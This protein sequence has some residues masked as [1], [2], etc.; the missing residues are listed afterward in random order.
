MDPLTLMEK[1]GVNNIGAPAEAGDTIMSRLQWFNQQMG[2][3]AV[4]QQGHRR[5]A[6]RR[7]RSRCPGKW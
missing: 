3:L 4:G 6:G 7:L 1:L 5:L 2:G